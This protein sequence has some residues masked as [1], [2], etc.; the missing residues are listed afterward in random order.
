MSDDSPA[1]IA[2]SASGNPSLESAVE[3]LLRCAHDLER[4]HGLDDAAVRASLRKAISPT[5]EIAFAGAFSAGK[6]MLINAL[7]GR[8]LLYSAEGH[9]TGTECYIAYAKP[10]QE[11]VVLTFASGMELVEEA[12]LL[13]TALGLPAALGTALT[14]TEPERGGAIAQACTA[15]IQQEGGEARS[16]RAKRANALRLLIEGWQANRDR[17]D[18]RQHRTYAMEDFQFGHLR[19]AAAYARRGYNSA[20]LKRIE[21]YCHHPLLEDG[22]V[23]VDLPGIDAPVQRDVELT[24]RKIMDPDTSAVVAV[25]KPAAAGEMSREE[26][27][28]LEMISRNA[29]IRDRVFFVFNRVDETWYNSQRR[30][31]F[32]ALLSSQFSGNFRTF[33]TSALLGFYGS[34]LR[35]TGESNHYGLDGLFSNEGQ[36]LGEEEETPQFVYEFNR[37]CSSSGKLPTDRFRI[38][39]NNYESQNDNYLRILQTYGSAL[40]EQLI[41]DSGI[42]EFSEAILNY[43]QTEKRPQLFKNLAD[44][45]LPICSNLKRS[46]EDRWRELSC[47]P[48]E[49]EGLQARQLEQLNQDLLAIAR[50]LHQHLSE[51]INAIVTNHCEAFEED[52]R[53]L[54][55]HMVQRLDA[56]LSNFSVEAAYRRATLAHPRNSTA[57][58]LAIL[59]EAFYHLANELEEILVRETERIITNLFA[60]LIDRIMHRPYYRDLCRLVGDDA[61]FLERLRAVGDRVRLELRSAASTE[62]DR[63]VRE[64][65]EFYK[66]N[67]PSLFQFQQVLV[68]AATSFDGASMAL[69]EPA[70][71]QLLKLD[72]EPKVT[73]T[74]KSTFR[75]AVHQ[76]LKR[77][78][79]ELATEYQAI[80]VQLYGRARKHLEKVLE[81]EAQAQLDA[82]EGQQQALE[83]AIAT[84]NGAI[85]VVDQVLTAAGCDR[86]ALPLVEI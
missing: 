58:L 7:L 77:D 44:D 73:K 15:I 13:V 14:E 41:E 51:E 10:D 28:L 20:V 16:E 47:Q 82:L 55:I 43:L 3:T 72:F 37:Y 33:Q 32:E 49:I 86:L 45:L 6:S 4:P 71:R 61:E 38:S 1:A 60:M 34:L 27:R 63:Y 22:N 76:T 23:L 80:V 62:C 83:D 26:T 12:R 40:I 5:F 25:L 9:A 81:Q 48:R 21:Y 84:Y 79:L 30:Q 64:N 17:I 35:K 19:E 85:E 11:R 75:Q 74:I 66:E 8:E 46:Y 50:D 57:P 29:G 18:P 69:A 68:Q 56:L 2:T 78:V 36:A 54:Q 52:F 53:S 31:R 70:V 67:T 24:D 39:V 59:V 42:E 65:P